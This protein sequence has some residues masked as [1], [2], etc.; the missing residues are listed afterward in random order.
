[1]ARH[2]KIDEE[3]KIIYANILALTEKEEAEIA[4]YQKYGY[5]VEP[6][7]NKSKSI[8]R[9]TKKYILDYLNDE[10]K[11]PDIDGKKAKDVFTGK[12]KEDAL[13]EQGNKKNTKKDGTGKDRKKGYNN[14][15]HWFART[16][17]LET[18]E[19]KRE[20]T[21][22]GKDKDFSR[23]L[24]NY[25]ADNAESTNKMNEEEYTRFFY[26]TKVFENPNQERE[27]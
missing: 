8:V 10:K 6:M 26:W 21:Q 14:A 15:L 7:A 11:A 13:D 9:L 24:K 2:Y 22:A 17:P 3:K 23:A 20:I 5:S 4:K 12:M 27:E 19:I 1:M 16:Y 18:T 25:N